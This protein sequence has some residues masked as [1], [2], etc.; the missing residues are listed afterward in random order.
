MNE[1]VFHRITSIGALDDCI[2]CAQF[3][4]GVIKTYDIKKLFHKV[5]AF[6]CSKPSLSYFSLSMWTQVV[7]GLYG[8]MSLIWIPTKYGIM[9]KLKILHSTI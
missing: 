7:M 1:F 9:V 5:P 8:I 4:E 2:L 3:E 6:V